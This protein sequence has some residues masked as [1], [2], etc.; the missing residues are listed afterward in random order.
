MQVLLAL[1]RIEQVEALT[2]EVDVLSPFQEEYAGEDEIGKLSCEH[3]YH[4]TCIA[5]WLRR[6]NWCPICKSSVLPSQ[7]SG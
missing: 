6:K 2:H 1:E 7:K 3:R 5:Q 4:A